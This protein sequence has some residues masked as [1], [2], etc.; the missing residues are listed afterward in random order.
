MEALKTKITQLQITAK[1]ADGVLAK[2][3]DESIARH[4]ATLQTVINEVDN[5]HLTIEAE[6]IAA[7]EDTTEWN[8]EINNEID[9]QTSASERRKQW[10]EKNKK[11]QESIEREEK[12]QFEVKLLGTK[13][14]L[15][16]EHEV[17]SMKSNERLEDR[18]HEWNPS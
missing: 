6:K 10:L 5:L 12:L 1:R 14:K 2:A 13:L 15:Q 7:K 3:D 11:E 17:A 18:N 8:A 4:Q 9:Q 16:A